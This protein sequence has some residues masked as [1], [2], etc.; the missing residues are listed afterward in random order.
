[1]GKFG[2]FLTEL[3]AHDM[4]LFSFL[5]LRARRNEKEMKE[6]PAT[7]FILLKH[8]YSQKIT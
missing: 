7:R 3:S 2:Y 6:K 1:M 4:S 5:V 8:I